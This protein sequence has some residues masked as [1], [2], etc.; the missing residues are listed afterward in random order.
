MSFRSLSCRGG[1]AVCVAAFAAVPLAHALPVAG[2]A[3]AQ[4]SAVASSA[5]PLQL[6]DARGYRHCHNLPRRTYCHKGERLPR[7]WPANTDTPARNRQPCWENK[8][9]CL[10]GRNTSKH[11]IN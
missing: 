4:R 1:A 5:A 6:V 9:N 7:N 10:F 2:I 3:V 8:S 11:R